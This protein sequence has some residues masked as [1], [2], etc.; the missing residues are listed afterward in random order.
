MID[1]PLHSVSAKTPVALLVDG[2]NFGSR[3][4]EGLLREVGRYGAPTVRRVYGRLEHIAEWADYGFRLQPTRPGKNSADILLAVEAMSLA[5]RESFHTI[6]VASSDRDFTYLAEHLR[7]LGHHIVGVGEIKAPLA[8][9]ACCSEFIEVV[10]AAP[11]PTIKPAPQETKLPATKV[12]PL[13]RKVLLRSSLKE[14][15]AYTDWIEKTLKAAD[16]AF[17]SMIY[18][19]QTF[20]ELIRSVNFF[21]TETATNGKFRLR[22]SSKKN[23]TAHPPTP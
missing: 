12:I 5:L 9:R 11:S 19:H 18:G 6:F 21:E 4:A 23:D 15:W 13:V 16:P 17:S 22:D 14:G 7:E 10:E 2:E 1:M 20:D 8:F 3:W